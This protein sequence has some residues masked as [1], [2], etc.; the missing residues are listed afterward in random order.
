MYVA[1]RSGE[2]L[3]KLLLGVN[4]KEWGEGSHDAGRW[5]FSSYFRHAP[6]LRIFCKIK[7]TSTI[8]K[9]LV[10]FFL[11]EARKDN[12][13]MQKG[14]QEEE[15]QDSGGS[16]WCRELSVWK[17][18]RD[19]ELLATAQLSQEIPVNNCQPLLG[20][21]VPIQLQRAQ[22]N[23]KGLELQVRD[24]SAPPFRSASFR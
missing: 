20:P 16:P 12:E 13:E 7:H 11:K 14:N 8:F 15:Q 10:I 1:E 21:R 3:T 24:G 4:S 5:A 2:I 23:F 6:V 18:S 9:K 19:L 22:N 17:G